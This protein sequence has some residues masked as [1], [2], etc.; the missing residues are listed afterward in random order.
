MLTMREVADAASAERAIRDDADMRE[1]VAK[2]AKEVAWQ[3]GFAEDFAADS[4]W[5][6]CSELLADYC[7]PDEDEDGGWEPEPE[8]RTARA[9]GAVA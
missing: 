1:A 6:Y 2:L 7:E 8:G 3:G 4:L 9:V 5:Q